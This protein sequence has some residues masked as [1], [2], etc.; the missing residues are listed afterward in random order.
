MNN[1]PASQLFA[2]LAGLQFTDQTPL[3]VLKMAMLVGLSLYAVFA[4]VIIRQVGLMTQTVKTSLNGT[5][6]LISYAH[7]AATVVVWLLALTLL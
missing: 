2:M 4:L 1:T 6:R 7:M 5:L 3:L